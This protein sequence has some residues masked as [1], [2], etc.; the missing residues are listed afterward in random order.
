MRESIRLQGEVI[1][2]RLSGSADSEVQRGVEVPCAPATGLDVDESS[3]MY[4]DDW[5]ADGNS[6]ED[7]IQI[8][9]DDVLLVNVVNSQSQLAEPIEDLLLVI[10]LAIFSFFDSS[11]QVSI[12]SVLCDNT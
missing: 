1:R 5:I 3:R 8:S 6:V 10:F 4:V 7:A 2:A 11:V 12:F 9:M